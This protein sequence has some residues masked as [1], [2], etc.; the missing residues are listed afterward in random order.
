MLVTYADEVAL[1]GE[2]L[3]T[4]GASAM[5]AGVQARWLTEADLRGHPSHGLQRV[6]T[7]VGRMRGGLIEADSR[8]ELQW[9]SPSALVVDGRRG[10]GPVVGLATIREL[11]RRVGATGVAIG[12]VHGANHLGLLGP[13]VEEIAE[14]G[15]IGAAMTTSEALVHAWGGHTRMLGTNP[16]AIGIPAEQGPFVLDMATGAVSMGRV[17][18][19]ARTRIPLEEGWA[20]D[21][22]G[23]PTLDPD[24]AVAGAISPFGGPKGYGL[25][26]AVELLVAAL[27]G[28][29]LGTAVH[30][31]LDAECE[32]TKGD[33]FMVIDP[34]DFGVDEIPGRLSRYL[35]EVRRSGSSEP[36]K[37][38]AVPGDRSRSARARGLS[39]GFTVDDGVWR[40]AEELLQVAESDLQL[41]RTKR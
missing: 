39:E 17:L 37:E 14:D 13:Y 40:E 4:H 10:F 22:T 20:V 18:A 16:I 35:Q 5:P 7:I 38:V 33:L 23:A 11:V 1:I 9:R 31:T 21:D 26:L 29:A 27:T 36:G 2:I 34:G 6:R 32:S 24:L 28:T 25:G 8:P 41:E 3:R 19:H 12:A 30:G 15:L